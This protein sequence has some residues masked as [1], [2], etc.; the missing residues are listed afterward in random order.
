MRA[1]IRPTS[2]PGKGPRRLEKSSC[3]EMGS[4]VVVEGVGV[5]GGGV[6]R[7]PHPG[8]GDGVAAGVCTRAAAGHQSGRW[9]GVGPTL[10][11]LT[12]AGRKGRSGVGNGG[13]V[14]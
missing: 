13:P 9:E 7:G 14:S 8:V 10:Q 1:S 6:R 5:V 4:W 11:S 12:F 3:E 2:D